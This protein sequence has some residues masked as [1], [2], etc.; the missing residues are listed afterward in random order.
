MVPVGGARR[1]GVDCH[2]QAPRHLHGSVVALEVGLHALERVEA[3]LLV[4]AGRQVIL[5]G[6]P[7]VAGPIGLEEQVEGIHLGHAQ[8]LEAL[9]HVD[10][11]LAVLLCNRATRLIGPIRV[12]AQG[13]RVEDLDR[14][15]QA[16]LAVVQ[17]HRPL[18]GAV[19]LVQALQ[20]LRQTV[21]E[22]DGVWIHLD[23]PVV[24]PDLPVSDQ[25]LP[26]A[27]EDRGVQRCVE[28]TAHLRLEG[29]LHDVVVEVLI[30]GGSVL[31]FD[32][33]AAVHGPTGAV[34]DATAPPRMRLD[35]V[36]L[37]A[38]WQHDGGAEERWVRELLLLLL[39]LLPTVRLLL[40]SLLKHEDLAWLQ[41]PVDAVGQHDLAA[42]LGAVVLGVQ[43]LVPTMRPL[44]HALVS[45]RQLEHLFHGAVVAVRDLQLL[46]AALH[47][48]QTHARLAGQLDGTGASRR[49]LEARVGV[50][51]AG[52]G[53]VRAKHLW[54]S[55]TDVVLFLQTQDAHAKV[56]DGRS[57]RPPD[58]LLRN[59]P[60][61]L[62]AAARVLGGEVVILG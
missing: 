59:M 11:L 15:V 57:R 60:V 33:F 56:A 42:R 4:V 36:H 21:G 22:E 13:L 41:R 51:A 54:T 44:E 19:G 49:Q 10:V 61:V 29:A 5:A 43:A 6:G 25:L 53:E 3:H 7:L 1:Y 27:H 28:L 2:R 40:G 26:E 46:E 47:Y 8:R 50:L 12:G 34:E 14:P 18:C 30:F 17:P 39:L 16:Q 35:H 20:H 23:D 58:L 62:V 9:T 48:S 31:E 38:P 24:V 45:V 32:P 55:Q 52:E 37:V